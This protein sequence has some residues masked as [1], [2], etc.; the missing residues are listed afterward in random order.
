MVIGDENRGRHG[1]AELIM[2][3]EHLAYFEDFRSV[4]HV[5]AAA[6]ME[7]I[8]THTRNVN[9]NLRCIVFCPDANA[10]ITGHRDG[11]VHVHTLS[12]LTSH[13]H[14]IGVQLVG[15]PFVHL[16][17]SLGNPLQV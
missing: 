3:D 12:Q 4:F 14:S 13:Q 16:T 10:V 15:V 6:A 11:I 2:N 7:C 17:P 9:A 1:M 8:Y 5:Y